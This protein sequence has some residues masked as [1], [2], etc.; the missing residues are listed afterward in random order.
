MSCGHLG[1]VTDDNGITWPDEPW[2]TDW[3]GIKI[4]GYV[5]ASIGGKEYI[6]DSPMIERLITMG[7]GKKARDFSGDTWW[8]NDAR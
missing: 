1:Y 7:I 5:T 3:L 8:P 4:N 6:L 2:P